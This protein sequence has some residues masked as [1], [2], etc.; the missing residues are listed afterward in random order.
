MGA[1]LVGLECV[2]EPPLPARYNARLATEGKR[3]QFR[4]VDLLGLMVC[5]AAALALLRLVA[6]DDEPLGFY[7]DAVGLAASCG[8]FFGLAVG[9][10]NDIMASAILGFMIAGCCCSFGTQLILWLQGRQ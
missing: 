9:G 1:G 5:I 7:C 10:R 2:A 3:R 8:A 4:I 6:T